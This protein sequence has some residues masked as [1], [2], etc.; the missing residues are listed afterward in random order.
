MSSNEFADRVIV[1]TGGTSGIGRATAR[2]FAERGADVVVAGRD[3]SA[4][5]ETV[6][7]IVRNGGRA[8]FVETDL[9]SASARLELAA[10]VPEADVL[11]NSAGFRAPVSPAMDLTESDFDMTFDVNVKAAYFLSAAFGQQMAARGRGAI[12][13]VSSLNALRNQPAFA[14][15]NASKAALDGLT[16]AFAEEL[17]PA[18]VRVNSVAPGPTWTPYTRENFG[19][20]LDAAMST[21][22]LPGPAEADQVAQVV[23]FLASEAA[24]RI[25]GTVLPVDGGR[26][27]VLGG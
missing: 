3:S 26:H 27:A 13:N 5:A 18:G 6:E 12:V 8:R 16:R 10:T 9:C 25:T 1:I 11:V 7:S 24:S 21:N 14:A 17:G 20:V 22:P 4:G 15:Y 23:V 19:D 2:R